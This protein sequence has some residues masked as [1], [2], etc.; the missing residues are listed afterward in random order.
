MGLMDI[1][2]STRDDGG[3]IHDS[4]DSKQRAILQG[5]SMVVR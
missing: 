2:V 1:G 5:T 4:S 3:D